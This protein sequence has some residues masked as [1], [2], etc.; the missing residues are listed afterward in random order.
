[1]LFLKSVI[2]SWKTAAVKQAPRSV[3]IF[4]GTENT[5]IHKSTS[6]KLFRNTQSP[7]LFLSIDYRGMHVKDAI[8]FSKRLK[9]INVRI[10]IS[11]QLFRS[12]LLG[13]RPSFTNGNMS[14]K[15][16]SCAVSLHKSS[17]DSVSSSC[18]LTHQWPGPPV[19]SGTEHLHFSALSRPGE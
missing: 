13:F 4:S 2:T 8:L 16:G 19:N 6:C 12:C 1:M 5:F 11:A 17:K 3:C 10:F 14:C 9:Q 15:T 7:W 18:E